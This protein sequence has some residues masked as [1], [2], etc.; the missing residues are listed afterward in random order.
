MIESAI[1]KAFY[2]IAED[3]GAL[4][5]IGGYDPYKDEYL[6]SIIKVPLIAVT[7]NQVVDQP[8]PGTD[9]AITGVLEEPEDVL[10]VTG[11]QVFIDTD[12]DGIVGLNEFI[13]QGNQ[14]I[15]IPILNPGQVAVEATFEGLGDLAE[16][17][18]TT[19]SAAIGTALFDVGSS[20]NLLVDTDSINLTSDDILESVVA[21]YIQAEG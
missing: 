15:D 10:D 14:D 21:N 11:F 1:S 3:P 16:L 5:M 19:D 6:V 18:N 17:I 20:I 2:Q 8:A 13:Q 4:K 7:G 12:G 9:V